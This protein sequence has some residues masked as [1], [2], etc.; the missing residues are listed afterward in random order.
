MEY[1]MTNEEFEQ[2]VV[3]AANEDAPEYDT[4]RKSLLKERFNGNAT[5][6]INEIS[7]RKTG[8][9][10]FHE[11]QVQHFANSDSI[12]RRLNRGV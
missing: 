5:D 10:M 8:N 4:H 9:I 1:K 3:L 11:K 2:L 7:H 12:T 6:M